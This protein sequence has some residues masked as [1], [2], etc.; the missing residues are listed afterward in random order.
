[1]PWA[2]LKFKSGPRLKVEVAK[3]FAERNKGLMYRTSLDKNKG[4]LFVF[5]NPQRLSFWMKNTYIA[6]S[7]AYFDKNKILKEIHQLKPQSMME[8]TQDLRSYPSRCLCQYVLE[9]NQ[10]WFKK[11]NVKVGDKFSFKVSKIK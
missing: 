2:D 10:G 9:V 6:L 3:T 11:N 5:E 7:L 8:R 4:M 1:M